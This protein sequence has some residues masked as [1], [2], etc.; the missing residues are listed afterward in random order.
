[1]LN[2][3]IDAG[4]SSTKVVLLKEGEVCAQAVVL[5]GDESAEQM[6]ERCLKMAVLKA[7]E[8][9]ETITYVVTTGQG[10][11]YISFSDDVVPDFMCLARGINR[12]LPSVQT[13]L[14]VGA[15][16]SLAVKCAGGSVV[17]TANNDKCAA[18]AGIYLEMVSKLLDVPL[19]KL[20][21]LPLSSTVMVEV[22]STCAV[23]AESEIISLI[24]SKKKP[25]DILRGVCWGLAHRL[26]PLL[27]QVR[28]EKDVAMVG[29]VAQNMGVRRAL[30]EQLGCEIIVP[31]N[32]LTVAALGAAII[33]EER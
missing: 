22:D 11:K 19:E 23:F 29:G 17:A 8:T 21:E 20:A 31:D 24:H 1:V 33:A 26:Y 28:F 6:A 14:D 3:G 12:I 5:G 9:R 18:G 32:P 16:K 25:E 27:V 4:L 13:V 10:R 7:G 2:A 15:Q 30:E